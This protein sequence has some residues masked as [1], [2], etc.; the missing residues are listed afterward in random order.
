MVLDIESGQV[1]EL[2][3]FERVW[4]PDWTPDGSHVVFNSGAWESRQIIDLSV[5]DGELAAGSQL[6]MAGQ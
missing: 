6:S 3:Q 4:G 2:G 1:R 5:A